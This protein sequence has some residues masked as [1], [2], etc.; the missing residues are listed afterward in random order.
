MHIF[1]VEFYNFQ[2]ESSFLAPLMVV[3]GQGLF[4]ISEKGQGAF[5]T[6]KKEQGAIFT[7]KKRQGIF[8]TF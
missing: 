3:E 6:P 7:F 2:Q 1:Q 8:L 4:F 5:L